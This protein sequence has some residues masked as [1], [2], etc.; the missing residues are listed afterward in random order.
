MSEVSGLDTIIITGIAA[1]PSTVAAFGAVFALKKGNL[2]SEA[3]A[4]THEKV[5]VIDN[6]VNGAAPGADSIRQN[7]QTLVKRTNGEGHM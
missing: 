5:A 3:I 2:N 1:I 7:V 4:A 6:A